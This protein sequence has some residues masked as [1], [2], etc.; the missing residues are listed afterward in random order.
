MSTK[1][2][3]PKRYLVPDNENPTCAQE[4]KVFDS[5]PPRLRDLLH[6]ARNCYP[7]STVNNLLVRGKTED[8]VIRIIKWNE[9]NNLG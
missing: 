1:T 2:Q 7:S 9:V 6:Y 3:P 8:E 5:L 4:M